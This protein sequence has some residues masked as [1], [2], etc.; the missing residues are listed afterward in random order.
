MSKIE[1]P[2]RYICRFS[3][4]FYKL[5]CIK[6]I[7][8]IKQKSQTSF[9]MD[10]KDVYVAKRLRPTQH[11][12]ESA[13]GKYELSISYYTYDGKTYSRGIV[14]GK[15]APMGG[16]LNFDI[17]RDHHDFPFAFTIRDGEEWLVCARRHTGQTMINLDTGYVYDN[18]GEV[19]S[20]RWEKILASPDGQ[21]FMMTGNFPNW[22]KQIKFY[23][24]K[25]CFIELELS[26]LLK[27]PL[28]VL[29]DTLQEGE[30]SIEDYDFEQDNR[31]H[32]KR[33]VR[34]SPKFFEFYANL[35]AKQL[36]EAEDDRTYATVVDITLEREGNKMVLYKNNL[37]RLT[38]PRM[39]PDLDFTIKKTKKVLVWRGQDEYLPN[40][41]LDLYKTLCPETKYEF[42]HEI[43]RDDPMLIK[44]AEEYMATSTTYL[45]NGDIVIDEVRDEL[46]WHFKMSTLEG[47]GR[48]DTIETVQEYFVTKNG[49]WRCIVEPN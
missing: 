10:V 39:S 23:E 49:K 45:H 41:I 24:F 15:N 29:C 40:E 16:V 43:P 30:L 7:T 11:K 28:G 4:T 5:I 9:G 26:L 13:T 38:T 42:V 27:Y 19:N 3:D 25:E 33:D 6:S 8:K 32:Y 48:A 1:P 44:A 20:F 2:R 17:K 22:D 31:F 37:P 46:G 21:T 18:P 12:Y 35:T 34:Y 36:V 14:T 47:T